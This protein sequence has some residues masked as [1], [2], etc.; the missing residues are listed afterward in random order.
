[1]LCSACEVPRPAFLRDLRRSG[2]MMIPSLSDIHWKF[3]PPPYFALSF[4]PPC[5]GLSLATPFMGAHYRPSKWSLCFG[6]ILGFV[7]SI[8]LIGLQHVSW[9]NISRSFCRTMLGGYSRKS[10]SWFVS[11]SCPCRSWDRAVERLRLPCHSLMYSSELLSIQ[12]APRMIP[13]FC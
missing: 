2:S 5:G 6:L 10:W 7:C 1:M 9:I 11:C 12:L 3:Y 8:L 4:P 13:G